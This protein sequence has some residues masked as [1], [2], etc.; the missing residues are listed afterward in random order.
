MAVK[1]VIILRKDLN[2]RKGKM[3]AQGAHASSKVF[4]DKLIPFCDESKEKEN[5]YLLPLTQE[6]TA[7]IKGDYRKVVV[8][9]ESEQ[10]LL[11]RY[12]QAESAGL[13]CSLIQDLG[14]T[15]FGGK[16]TYT[17]VAIGPVSDNKVDKI[18]GD[19]PLL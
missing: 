5:I 13:P 18:T 1:Q 12:K 4:M 7:W 2:M 8:Y 9:V 17:A 10:A 15:E 16:K 6:M 19:L 14:L 11:E 3:V